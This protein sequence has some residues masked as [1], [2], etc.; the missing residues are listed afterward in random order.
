[1]TSFI[2]SDKQNA[3]HYH[4]L[5]PDSGTRVSRPVYDL[6]IGAY[7]AAGRPQHAAHIFKKT[8][9]LRLKPNVLTCNT[10]LNVLV[11]YP[12]HHTFSLSKDV[13]ED[14]ISLGVKVNSNTFNIVIK[15]CCLGSK[16]EEALEL[17]DKM[18]LHGCSPD[19]VTHN[20]IW[21][22]CARKGN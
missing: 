2:A 16:F 19:N 11:K 8:K 21:T 6:S 12:S 14:V 3:L 15:G 5:H 20:T 13:L 17:V 1:M 10:L 18:T 22:E 7:V 9:R 4:I